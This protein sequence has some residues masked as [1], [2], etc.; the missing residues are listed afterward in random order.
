LPDM[1]KPLSKWWMDRTIA[2]SIGLSW[3]L[4]KNLDSIKIQ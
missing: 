4:K 3:L 2:L 1:L